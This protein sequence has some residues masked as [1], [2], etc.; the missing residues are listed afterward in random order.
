MHLSNP[1][2]Q[3]QNPLPNDDPCCASLL[4]L[5]DLVSLPA[6]PPNA[7]TGNPATPTSASTGAGAASICLGGGLSSFSLLVDP[8][9]SADANDD[10]PPHPA[11]FFGGDPACESA[12]L[13]LVE[14]MSESEFL[15]SESRVGLKNCAS[16]NWTG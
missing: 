15:G 5:C 11:V 1:T 4:A 2:K 9:A 8:I 10:R 7:P 12:T 14:N 3:N 13:K 16:R 6:P